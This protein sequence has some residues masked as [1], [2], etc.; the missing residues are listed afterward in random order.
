MPKF[1]TSLRSRAIILV[2]LAILPL[3][4][5]TFYSYLGERNRTVN[6]VH[7]DAVIAARY[8][9]TIQETIIGSTRQVLTHLAQSPQ[10][11]RGDPEGCTALFSGLLK[12]SPWYAVIGAA[13]PDG[14]VFASAPLAP[15]PVNV[16]NRLFFQKAVQS[17]VFAVGEPL[18]CRISDKYCIDL[19]YPILDEAGG[20]KGVLFV[21]VDLNWLG[22]LLVKSDFPVSTGLILADATGRVL[23]R[24]PEPLKYT[25]RMLP[26][27]VIKVMIS[28]VDGVVESQEL[29]GDL[30]LIGFTRLAPPWQAMRVAISLRK[31]LA[32]GPL[33]RDLWRD[34]IWLTAVSLSAGLAAWFG[35]NIFILQPVNNLLEVTRRLTS[36][37]LTAR[38]G[39]PHKSGELGQLAQAFDQMADSLQERD[40]DLKKTAAELRQ[41]VKELKRRSL[42]LAA[43]NKELENFTYSVAHDLRAP[44]R[45]IGGFARVLLEDYPDRLDDNGVRYLNIIH[46]DASKMGRLIDDLLALA[47]LGRKEIRFAPLG[48]ADLVQ[49][50]FAELKVA[51]P[52]RNLQIE[53]KPLPDSQGDRAMIRQVLD[54]LLRNAVKFTQGRDIALIQ[55]TGWANEADNVYCI[56]DNGV[57][58]DM[59]YV[60]KL[61]GAF[62]RL[63]PENEFEG[64][65]MGLAIAKRIIER[66]AGRMWAESII[67]EGSAFYFTIPQRTVT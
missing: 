14:Q 66:H 48:M 31:D 65:G 13:D 63:H 47:R 56:R 21:G 32:L 64:T 38:S 15:A 52:E 26:E 29:P 22:N 46:Q 24:Y 50:I 51:N 37:D 19:S 10:V 58:F 39:A 7:R 57:G 6:E 8:L 25:G 43:A 36:G 61:F 20:L 27:G 18:L 54:N 67:N 59:K 34:L 28:R 4:A 41:R 1:L 9:A 53:I 11:Q 60:N 2:L 62:Q 49:E 12:Q 42:E 17:R 23:F 35:G 44:L 33:N 16:A 55:V 5:L 3:L 45:A 30:R 40:V